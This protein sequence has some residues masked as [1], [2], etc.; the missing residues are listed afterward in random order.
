MKK[1]ILMF[2]F[3]AGPV[4]A[5][6]NTSRMGLYKPDDGE[7]GWGEAIRDNYDI[8]DSSVAILSSTQTFTG[9]VTISSGTIGRL[10]S[11]QIIVSSPAYAGSSALYVDGFIHAVSGVN[12]GE[13]NAIGPFFISINN[14]NAGGSSIQFY[15]DGS[16]NQSLVIRPNDG[17]IY[18]ANGS[19]EPNTISARRII[20]CKDNCFSFATPLQEVTDFNGDQ[21]PSMFQYEL[22]IG[23]NTNSDKG[24][25]VVISSSAY[26]YSLMVGTATP[27]SNRYHLTVSTMG[28]TEFGERARLKSFTLAQIQALTN[29]MPVAG[30]SVFC[31]NCTT[32]AVCVSTGGVNS[33]VRTSARTT[34]CQ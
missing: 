32:D 10:Y 30:D 18:F 27:N 31:S 22:Y 7:T 4:F 19:N 33:F 24:K 16:V 21:N 20:S 6:S 1:L 9:G 8:I 14:S 26:S 12:V 17:S 2:L 29:P 23:T 3:M 15:G 13:T 28:V 11:D 5:G 25:L 34:A